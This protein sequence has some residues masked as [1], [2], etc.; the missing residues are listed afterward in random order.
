M[1]FGSAGLL[2][3]LQS[4]PV[5]SAY[6]VAYSGGLDSHVLLHALAGLRS[7]LAVPVHAIHV[8][9]GLQQVADD[10][11]AHCQTVC[12]ELDVPLAIEYLGLQPAPGESVEAVAREAR[13]A[14][15]A[16][17]LGDNEMLLTAQHRDDQAETLLLQLLRGAGIEGLAGMPANRAWQTGWHARPLLGYPREVLHGYAL[18]HDLE[19]IDDPSNQDERFDRNYLRH[20]VM[21]ALQARWPSAG[22]TLARSAAHLGSAMHTL[23]ALAHDDLQACLAEHGCLSVASLQELPLARRQGVIRA[24]VRD[25]G[26]PLPDRPR[27]QQIEQS[28][29]Q[30]GPGTSPQV[31]WGGVTLRRYRDQLWLIPA[32]RPEP[33]LDPLDWP[34]DEPELQLPG[35]L[36]RLQ[37]RPAAQGIADRYWHQGR[38]SVGWRSEGLGC[39]PLGRE[40]TRPFKKLCQE[41]GIPPWE[42]DRV[43]L[44]F[45]EGQLLAVADYCLCGEEETQR[46]EAYSCLHWL[47]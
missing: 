7:R 29:L 21:P 1:T 8:H 34:A 40:G 4:L 42:R 41:L 25:C 43:P 19:W 44:L 28:V 15:I 30:A 3:Q 5:P 39:R 31:S 12:R 20:Q 32:H 6:L 13:Y 14:A 10:W 18:D 11:V 2:E 45:V 46:G 47:R 26:R 38:V 17:H 23:R 35:G 16:R 37:R 36:G 27:M 24:W 22:A 9:H 33:P